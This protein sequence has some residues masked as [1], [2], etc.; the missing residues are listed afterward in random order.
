MSPRL[1]SLLC[2]GGLEG[3]ATAGTAQPLPKPPPAQGSLVCVTSE[4]Q[5][6]HKGHGDPGTS[7]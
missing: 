7:A 4:Q 1:F 5:Q 3:A 2:R 6:L